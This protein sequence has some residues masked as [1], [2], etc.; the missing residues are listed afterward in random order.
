MVF[1][2]KVFLHGDEEGRMVVVTGSNPRELAQA[3]ER[4]AEELLGRE[5]GEKV[6][7]VFDKEVERR[8]EGE[9]W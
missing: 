7:E 3:V 5:N 1:D 9:L 4:A 6:E 2:A 8:R